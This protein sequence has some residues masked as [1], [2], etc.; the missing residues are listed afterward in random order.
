MPISKEDFFNQITAIDT[1]LSDWLR[2]NDGVFKD[3]VGLL[4]ISD[5]IRGRN[6]SHELC[7]CVS[8]ACTPMKDAFIK[9]HD[10]LKRRGL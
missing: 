10:A 1:E 7:C 8:W 6:I 5:P 4:V 9:T 2:G 3:R